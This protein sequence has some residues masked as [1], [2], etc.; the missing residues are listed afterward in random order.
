MRQETEQD[1]DYILREDRS[2]LELL[3]C[4]YTFLNERLARYYGMTNVFGEEMRRVHAAA[5]QPA[6]RNLDAGHRAGGDFQSD[7]DLA[8][9]ARGVHP[10]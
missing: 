3:D 9:Q 1:F 6:R 7:P 8:R 4:D 2:V 5:G 10:R